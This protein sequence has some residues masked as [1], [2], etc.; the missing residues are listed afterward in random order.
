MVISALA[1][2]SLLM[3]LT[4]TFRSGYW[5]FFRLIDYLIQTIK[6]LAAAFSRAWPLIFQNSKNNNLLE[7]SD[8]SLSTKHQPRALWPILRGLLLAL[9]ILIFSPAYLFP[10]FP[11]LAR[12]VNHHRH[13]SGNP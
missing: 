9:P 8:P 13:Y 1:S 3:L 11:A 10:S 4:I 5:P 12:F 7:P 6:W 2:L